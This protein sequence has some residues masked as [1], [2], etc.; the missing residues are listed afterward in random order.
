M[1]IP[2]LLGNRNLRWLRNMLESSTAPFV[3]ITYYRKGLFLSILTSTGL[4]WL[5]LSSSG[6]APGCTGRMDR[7]LRRIDPLSCA[8]FS[9]VTADSLNPDIKSSSSG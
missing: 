4:F 3:D 7:R 2:V 5:V 8:E 6:F 9:S 1:L